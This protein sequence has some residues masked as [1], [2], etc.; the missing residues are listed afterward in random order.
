MERRIGDV[1]NYYGGLHVKEQN[2][3]YYWGIENWDGDFGWIEIPKQL[4]DALIQYDNQLN[5]K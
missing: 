2:G 1:C 4:F 3:K 5:A